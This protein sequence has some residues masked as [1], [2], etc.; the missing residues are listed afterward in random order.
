MRWLDCLQQNP[1]AYQ[2]FLAYLDTQIQLGMQQ[3]LHA[4]DFSGLEKVQGRIEGIQGLRHIATHDERTL[5]DVAERDA[6]RQRAVNG[7]SLR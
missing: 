3:F 7:T 6:R 2:D 5:R 1:D 4:K